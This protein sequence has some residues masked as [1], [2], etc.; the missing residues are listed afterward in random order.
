MLISF[1]SDSVAGRSEWQRLLLALGVSLVLHLGGLLALHLTRS[2]ASEIALALRSAGS[3]GSGL[4]LSLHGPDTHG[5]PQVAF[6]PA[7]AAGAADAAGQPTPAK[8]VTA[9]TEVRAASALLEPETMASAAGEQWAAE[10]PPSPAQPLLPKQ[11]PASGYF[12]GSELT[13]AAV[14]LDE[15]SIEP[16][17][18]SAGD[19]PH[20]GKV[21]LRI[22]L[23]ADGVVERIEV[24]SSTLPP[25]FDEAAVAA[26]SRLRFRPGEI[27]G[28]AVSSESRIEVVFDAFDALD[29][30]AAGSSHA[31]DRGA[32]RH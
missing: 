19:P 22:F 20:G 5:S 14:P 4:L 8:E 28:I 6:A 7:A 26:F 13:L 25:A 30:F 9:V 12:R 15:P 27:Q 17:D 10:L 32:G 29:A 18:E 1:F 2:E 16:P 23:S 21:V 11:P 3:T 24:A 31:S